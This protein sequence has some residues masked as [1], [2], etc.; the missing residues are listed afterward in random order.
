MVSF[1]ESRKGRKTLL[2]CKGVSN[3]DRPLVCAVE[4]TIN[5][6]GASSGFTRD[7]ALGRGKDSVTVTFSAPTDSLY[8]TTGGLEE[9][10]RMIK[11]EPYLQ[12]GVCDNCKKGKK[13]QCPR[14]NKQKI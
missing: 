14:H 10:A 12:S 11:D 4:R 1:K 13:S 3:A 5:N 6:L 2:V 8:G 9:Q 7:E